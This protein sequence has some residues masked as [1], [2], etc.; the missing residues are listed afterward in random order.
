ML[1]P[2]LVSEEP[3][4]AAL[5]LEIIA[6]IK[7]AVGLGSEIPRYRTAGAL[8]KLFL[9]GTLLPCMMESETGRQAEKEIKWRKLS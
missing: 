1:S 7:S 5:K 4:G 6:E 8:I 2:V 9:T 3:V